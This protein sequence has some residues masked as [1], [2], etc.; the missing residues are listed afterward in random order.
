MILSN[1][2]PK[3][4][5]KSRTSPQPSTRSSTL[6]QIPIG[7]LATV[8]PACV[9]KILVPLDFSRYSNSVLCWAVSF[10]EQFQAL[11]VLLYVAETTPAGAEFGASHLPQLEADL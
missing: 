8:S 7:R 1:P 4:F 6:K 5:M 3:A 11:I 2:P 10:A 9:R